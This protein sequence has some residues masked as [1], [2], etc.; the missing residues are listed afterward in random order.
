MFSPILSGFTLFLCAVG[1]KATTE[2]IQSPAAMKVREGHTVQIRCVLNSTNVKVTVEKSDVHWYNSP[3]KLT[4]R[5]IVLSLYTDGHVYRKWGFSKRFQLSRD[6]AH[7]S[8]VLTI[9]NVMVKDSD[10]YICGIWGTLF[11]MGT[12]L[13]VTSVNVPV[14][15]QS[16]SLERI[17]EGHTAR[18]CCAMQNAWLEKTDVHWYRE[19]PGQ[20]MEWVLTHEAGGATRRRANSPERF[21]PSR[22]VSNSSFILMVSDV[23]PGDSAVYYCVVWGD[24]SGN[25]TRLIVTDPLDD[26]VLTQYPAVSQV[27]EGVTVQMQCTLDKANVSN[28]DVHWYWQRPGHR[29]RWAMSH[30]VNEKVTKSFRISDRFQPFRNVTSNSYVLNIANASINDT[31]TYN[32]SVWNYIYGAGTQLNVTDAMAPVLIQSP[33]LEKVTEGQTTRLWCHMKNAGVGNTD[34]HWYRKLAGQEMDWVLTQEAGGATRRRPNST[35][36]LQ[37]SRDVSN[38]S[39]ILTVTDVEPLD[40]A[41]YY[42]VVWGDI[43]GDGSRLNV[44]QSVLFLTVRE[45]INAEHGAI[46]ETATNMGFNLNPECSF[47]LQEELNKGNVCN[48]VKFEI[49][50]SF[51]VI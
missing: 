28:T 20:G 31:A 32:C 14:L 25:G 23:E 24:I 38:S 46:I 7:N 18:L 15:I 33:S 30:F 1:L 45:I 39:F 21:E 37:P 11:G 34:V 49:Q 12:K 16:P 9:N 6:M 17:T 36:R 26:P 48:R 50:G 40:S 10:N 22:D 41:V 47:L 2:L 29:R 43:S 27:P 35:E 3:D 44:I 51:I 4:Q 19:L 8:Y 42:C 5:G 13:N